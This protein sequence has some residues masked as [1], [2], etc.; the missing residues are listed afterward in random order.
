MKL[1]NQKLTPIV[2]LQIAI[3]IAISFHFFGAIGMSK[4][5]S[6]FLDATPLNLIIC[7]GL[8][9]FTH[10]VIKKSFLL[11]AIICFAWGMLVELIGVNT[12]YLFGTYQYG[13][14]MG[15]KIFG[16]PWLIGL[17]WFVTIYIVSV[18]TDQILQPIKSL[19][20][21][22]F[23]FAFSVA[24]IATLYDYVIEPVAIKL[25]FWNWS[26]D[27]EVPNYNY[28]CWFL[29]SLPLA[30]LFKK[31]KIDTANQFAIYLLLI[32]VIFFVTLRFAL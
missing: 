6:F 1:I 11:F 16:V 22:N 8:I 15:W 19:K 27:P 24:A 32:Q 29:C 25:H 28:V 2:K 5:M 3:A 26:T 10:G 20:L 12:G 7:A 18:F 21:Y 9:L 23:F 4:K 13:T 30:F 17:N 14:I 31:M